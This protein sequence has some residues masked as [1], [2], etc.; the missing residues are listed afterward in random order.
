M[1]HT[2]ITSMAQRYIVSRLG[3]RKS[4][5][6]DDAWFSKFGMVVD[7]YDELLNGYM[8]FQTIQTTLPT[9]PGFYWWRQKDTD[10]W[11]MVQIINFGDK[12]KPCL[13]AYDVEF[14][15]FRGRNLKCW[16]EWAEKGP[17]PEHIGQ[18]VGP[19]PKPG[20]M[21]SVGAR[22]CDPQQRDDDKAGGCGSQTRAPAAADTLKLNYVTSISC[23]PERHGGGS[24]YL[25]AMERAGHGDQ[26]PA[27][28]R[29]GRWGLAVV[30]LS[31]RPGAVVL[32]GNG[33]GRHIFP[34]D[35]L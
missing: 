1:N 8:Q 4:Y 10:A 5:Q 23:G 21:P 7:A 32:R 6:D 31:L 3:T 34:Q 18:W 24:D 30:V 9:E 17:L 27:G 25:D 35:Y 28:Q 13:N 26:R 16:Q 14:C 2:L 20:D 15:S 33:G 12:E 22:V 11:R 29:G 19:L